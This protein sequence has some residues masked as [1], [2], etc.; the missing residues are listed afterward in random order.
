MIR[1]DAL[2]ERHNLDWTWDS[3]ARMKHQFHSVVIQVTEREL[4]IASTAW[5][6]IAY[7]GDMEVTWR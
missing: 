6:S 2:W 1:S 4:V 5:L 3:W 7:P